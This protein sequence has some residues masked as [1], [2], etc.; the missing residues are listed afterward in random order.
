MLLFANSG[1]IFLPLRAKEAPKYPAS[2]S[3]KPDIFSALKK[4]VNADPKVALE[5][6]QKILAQNSLS[7]QQKIAL[8]GIQSGAYEQLGNFKIGLETGQKALNLATGKTVDRNIIAYINNVVGK[9]FEG[10]GQIP[11]A[12]QSYQQAYENFQYSGNPRG[13]A[14]S[15][16]NIAGLF[17]GARLFDK[18]ISE[19]NQIL[20][21]LDPKKDIFLYTRALNNL[22]YTQIENGTPDKALKY[23]KQARKLARIMGNQMLIAYTY[24]NSGEAFYHTGHY[25]KAKKYFLSARKIAENNGIESLTAAIYYYLGLVE[26]SQKN[27]S[28][29]TIY[30]ARALKIALKNNAVGRLA[31]IYGLLSRQARHRQDY[32]AALIYRDLRLKYENRIDSNN[33]ITALALL[34]TEFKL[35]G[36]QQ[37]ITLLQRDNEI[38]RLSLQEEKNLRYFDFGLVIFLILSVGFLLYVLRIK[39]QATKLARSREK[40]LLESK[41]AAEAANQAKTTKFLSYMS[42]ELRTPLNAVIGFSEALRLPDFGKLN[43]KQTEYVSHIHDSGKLLLKLINDLLHLS[44]I[45]TGA[46]DLEL[47]QHNLSEIVRN[48]IPMVQHVLEKNQVQLHLNV[49][50]EGLNP[51]VVDK[52]RMDQI[53][54]NLISNAVKYGHQGGNI[55]LSVTEIEDHQL[56][57]SIQDDGIGIAPEQ[58]KNIFTPF[59]RA[60][61][62]QSGIEGTGA[63][64][65]IVKALIEAM[66]GSIGFDSTLGEGTTFWIDLPTVTAA[67]PA[68]TPAA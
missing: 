26:F 6:S 49:I 32:K 40:D 60:G 66:G 4:Q 64:L 44:K 55:W 52:I 21:L 27:F 22:G 37:Q 1:R 15:K 9:N 36:R 7:Q 19:Y 68:L 29:S 34:E 41:L 25:K 42:H 51:V 45:E 48:I 31:N 11:T 20:T 46:I 57:V 56:R 13:M 3:L 24:E 53:L 58:F 33:I 23:L 16:I 18:A 2:T 59:N 67:D 5:T 43:D 14:N 28:K 54:V 38:Q 12:M 65:S 50:P 30:A 35:K 61:M 63:G 17:V 47:K 8:I 62:E 39:S 10:L